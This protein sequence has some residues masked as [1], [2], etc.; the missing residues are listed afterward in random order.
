MNLKFKKEELKSKLIDASNEV[1]KSFI[2][3]LCKFT[4]KSINLKGE[5]DQVFD[6]KI[7]FSLFNLEIKSIE[8]LNI[9]WVFCSEDIKESAR[10]LMHLFG[11][12]RKQNKNI[13][14]DIDKLVSDKISSISIEYDNKGNLKI[15]LLKN[16]LEQKLNLLGVR[17]R[18]KSIL[19]S[20]GTHNR[21]LR[22]LK[23]YEIYDI[24]VTKRYYGTSARAR[25]LKPKDEK[26][27]KKML[28]P[29]FNPIKIP[30]HFSYYSWIDFP[31]VEKNVDYKS[32]IKGEE[33][34]KVVVTG[35][36]ERR[37]AAI[38]GGEYMGPTMSYDIKIED[39]KFECKELT[40]E[41]PY[42]RPGK[43]GLM[44]MIRF[45]KQLD[46]VARNIRNFSKTF[47]TCKSVDLD[48]KTNLII[49]KISSFVDD[50]YD[51]IVGTGEVCTNRL[52]YL[53]TIIN[54]I[55]GL[56]KS[57]DVCIAS[58]KDEDLSISGNPSIIFKGSDKNETAVIVNLSPSKYLQVADLVLRDK[59]LNTIATNMIKDHIWVVAAKHLTHA[60]FGEE[61]DAE[62]WL[63]NL[64]KKINVY[65]VFPQKEIAG[66]FIVNP[67]GFYYVPSKDFPKRIKFKTVS[68]GK[69]KFEFIK[70]S[71]RAKE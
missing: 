8:D 30:E 20:K 49:N 22:A 7:D 39:K 56:L 29:S 25:E 6:A 71:F 1:I 44:A 34:E 35:A 19:P 28:I 23:E 60:V 55:K 12:D 42:I 26:M 32:L 58:N 41:T 47:E 45:K 31:E 2:G 16:S 53:V 65:S 69:P 61:V 66:L 4:L 3:G 24:S 21:F 14:D 11:H 67:D 38:F 5:P 36:G 40:R 9:A 17:I 62:V 10:S 54:E 63:K 52:I 68:Q 33:E 57:N 48:Q 70:N 64:I 46:E 13:F 37:I 27:G 15:D 59:H 50:A 18:N 43:H 51:K